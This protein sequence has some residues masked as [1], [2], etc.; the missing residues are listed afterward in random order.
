M[1]KGARNHRLGTLVFWFIFSQESGRLGFP[2]LW[3]PRKH[4]QLI[5]NSCPD[6]SINFSPCDLHAHH[7]RLATSLPGAS[8]PSVFNLK[9]PCIFNFNC[10]SNLNTRCKCHLFCEAS[11]MPAGNWLVQHVAHF[12][13]TLIVKHNTVVNP[14]SSGDWVCGSQFGSD[15]SCVTWPQF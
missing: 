9:G 7:I 10:H 4:G 11:L 13:I 15:V 3:T 8:F 14:R 1:D 6:S 5:P 12:S 2:T